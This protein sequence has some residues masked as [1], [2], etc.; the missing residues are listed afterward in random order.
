MRRQVPEPVFPGTYQMELTMLSDG[1]PVKSI[2]RNVTVKENQFPGQDNVVSRIVDDVSVQPAQ[3]QFSRRPGGDRVRSVN[4]KNASDQTVKVQ[5]SAHPR[6]DQQGTVDWL[7]Y[8]PTSMRVPGGQS[9]Q[10][11]M[12]AS[13]G[14]NIHQYAFL[15]VSVEPTE[16]LAGGQQNIP[17]AFLG[18]GDLNVS[19]ESGQL[20]TGSRN[21]QP[22]LLLPVKNTGEVH[23]TVDAEMAIDTPFGEQ[24]TRKG[25]FGRWILPGRE[26]K[27]RFVL[28]EVPSKGTYP[29]TIKL[30]PGHGAEPV[31]LERTLKIE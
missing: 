26:K 10:V 11:F 21:R 15:E 7:T 25:G 31:K 28:D 27:I 24:I 22:A 5:L 4:V 6:G 9:R 30:N 14:E 8:R 1:R 12:S 29:V 19:I 3:I 17:V 2:S 20:Q 13:G 16:T 18:T 23:L